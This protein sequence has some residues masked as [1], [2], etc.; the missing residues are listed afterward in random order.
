MDKKKAV[1]LAT[2][3]AVAASAFVAANPH[4]SQAATDV[5]T[6][7]SQAK[8]QMKQAYYTYSHTVTE[9]G[10]LPNISDVYAAYNKA[11]QAYENAVAVVNKAGG[12][13]KDAY[14]ADL[15]A[16]YETY[17]FKANPKSGEARVATY[18]D[19]YNYATKLDKMRQELKA[20]VDAKDLKKAEELYHKISYELKT[21]TVIL[22]RVY[23]QST[24]E[25]LRSQFKAEAQ[26]LRDSLIYDITVAM[27]A[28]EAQ[29]AV[30][31]GNLDK[32]KAALDQVNQYVSKV[33]D[34]FKAE[35]QK[36]AQDANKAYEAALKVESVKAINNTTVEVTFKEAIDDVKA[37][38]F[39]IDGLEVKNAVLKQKT[40][41]VVVLTTSQQEGGKEYV[42]KLNGE[43]LGKFKG[44]SAYVP[45]TITLES[46]SV[47]SKVGKEVTLKANIGKKEAGV[48][49]TFNIDAP[50]G[51]L[52]EDKV[53]EVY[54][55]ADGIAEYTY[56]QYAAG[57][58]TV[59]VYPTGAPA[60]RDIA[61]VYWG[62]DNI[63][64]VKSTTD[65]NVLNNGTA[66]YYTVEL[67]D[68]KTGKG[69]KGV[70][71]NVTFAENIDD[72]TANDSK[73]V[74]TDPT[75]G[76]TAT[77][78]QSATGQ[79]YLT[80]TTDNEGKAGFTVTGANT[81]VTPIVFIDS[82]EAALKDVALA[83]NKNDRLDARELR[84]AAPSVE[85][86]GAQ[87]GYSITFDKATSFEGV[88]GKPY[89]YEV[90][91]KDK[92]GK[93]WAG[94]TINVA[95][96]ENIDDLLTTSTKARIT[97]SGTYTL[98]ATGKDGVYTLTLNSEGKAKFNVTSDVPNDTATPVV[99]IDQNNETAKQ[100]VKEAGE[101]QQLAG[102][103]TFRD[104]VVKSLDYYVSD[105]DGHRAGVYVAGN[106]DTPKFVAQLLD[107]SGKSATK[108]SLKQV[109][110]TITNTGN[111]EVKL[112][113]ALTDGTL[114]SNRVIVAAG[115][116]VTVKGTVAS[117]TA[118][119]SVSSQG[120][121]KVSVGISA[122]TNGSL[123]LTG[124]A[125][126]VEFVE[127]SAASSTVVGTVVGYN[128][129]DNNGKYGYVVIK[130]DNGKFHYVEYASDKNPTYYVGNDASFNNL[131][132]VK[133]DD[134]EKAISVNDRIKVVD[135]DTANAK[136]YLHNA[137]SSS[138][139]GQISGNIAPVAG[140]IVSAVL[141]DETADANNYIDTLTITFNK[142]LDVSS[143][144]DT[145][146]NFGV[147]DADLVAPVGNTNTLVFKLD[148][149]NSLP[150]G[151]TIAADALTFTDG[152]KIAAINF[153]NLLKAPVSKL[154]TVQSNLAAVTGSDAVAQVT[155][156]GKDAELRVA[157]KDKPS[158]FADVTFKFEQNN[159]DNLSVTYANKV[160]TVK[161]ANNNAAN[162]AADK[163]DAAIKALGQVD[164]KDF[165]KVSFV[166]A[167]SNWT[168]VTGKSISTASLQLAGGVD[169]VTATKGRYKFT[170]LR[171]LVEGE[172][173]TVNGITYTATSKPGAGTQFVIGQD[174][175][176][177]AK[178]LL[179][180]IKANDVRFDDDASS[181]TD[182][183]IT[184][185]DAKADGAAA[186]TVRY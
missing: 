17:V 109:T 158:Q 62:V 68:P 14:L 144:A 81:K 39:S 101:P 172:Q 10:K 176:E 150:T 106:A 174:V 118:T 41:N 185:V 15:Q 165:T 127:A 16:T 123:Y 67:K 7:V 53:V 138:K 179:N 102:S 151:I 178:N 79:K 50:T 184:L 66:K 146:F 80:I 131:T 58:D 22:D 18:I 30:K 9:T 28:R 21:R 182:S 159:S 125:K 36:A 140:R 121:G 129:T 130:D 77:P 8:A 137:D 19:A 45:T 89:T 78:Y 23:G 115:N 71:L 60:T 171:Q 95:L 11:K 51:S 114:E 163:I 37:L 27:K 4:A 70:K 40:N 100:H 29:D 183:T 12:A 120:A 161:L 160:V 84:V 177:T 90:T 5:A 96:N 94:G 111:K 117:S 26:K 136:Y 126:E 73:A 34:A 6:V 2:A 42:V 46:A 57:V 33:T 1:K 35:L 86:V 3:S 32:A 180:A 69:I 168:N 143:V 91:V 148:T 147:N 88:V 105:V 162:N 149:P 38:H 72:T 87:T 24:R 139:S 124:A 107:Q 56:T 85:F 65:S 103:V 170:L 59:S 112:D 153:T 76:N 175:N 44:I 133:T 186:P 31:A 169:A 166:D 83:G 52:N 135:A 122:V 47:Q 110:Y 128:T 93:P 181:V 132:A 104:E 156:D 99:W 20:A 152:T 164:G 134:F 154:Y 25:L 155:V 43:E 119:L 98:G 64:T 49:V 113:L 145:D 157:K 55:N 92:D 61:N 116:S 141:S 173:I 167:D 142:T 13:K 54:T 63:L 108:D 48:P 75:T 82:D 74:V 97:P